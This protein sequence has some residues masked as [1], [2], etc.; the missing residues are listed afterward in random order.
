MKLILDI[1]KYNTYIIKHISVIII[2]YGV[3]KLIDFFTKDLKPG[4]KQ[5]EALRSVAFQEGVIEEIALRFGYSPRSLRALVYRLLKGKHQLFPEVKRGPK[6]RHT[7]SETAKLIIKLRR[8]KK[9][10]STDL[11]Q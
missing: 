5:Y 2:L 8:E 6:S 3:M 10:N 4:Q 7:S 1:H 9:L 11:P